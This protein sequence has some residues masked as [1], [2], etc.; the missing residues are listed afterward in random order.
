MDSIKCKYDDSK[1]DNTGENV[2]PKN[3]YSNPFEPA[4][5]ISLGLGCYLCIYREKFTSSQSDSLFLGTGELGTASQ[6]YCAQLAELLHQFVDIVKEHVRS[7]HANTHGLHK[8]SAVHAT[9]GM[10]CPPPLPSVA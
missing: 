6:R 7:N 8:G 9:S 4:I 2:S 1:T 10:T 3:M 5:D